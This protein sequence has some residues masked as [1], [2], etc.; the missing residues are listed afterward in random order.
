MLPHEVDTMA[1]K[2]RMGANAKRKLEKDPPMVLRKLTQKKM[3]A[4]HDED[5]CLLLSTGRL[6]DS[7]H[8]PSVSFD[9][10]AARESQK[11]WNNEDG[12]S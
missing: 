8:N 12:A 11:I 7:T 3:D 1:E 6:P 2:K 5:R 9:M 10:R 4:M